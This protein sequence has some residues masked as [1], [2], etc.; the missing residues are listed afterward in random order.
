MRNFRTSR[1]GSRESGRFGDRDS[2]NS[3]GRDR[4]DRRDNE[5]SERPQMHSVVCDKC[6]ENCEV[7]FRPTGDKPVYCSACF[8]KG[9]NSRTRPNNSSSELEQINKKLDKIMEALDIE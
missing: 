4:F 2:G 3:R 5:R 9:D 1:P 7:P 8:R 6:G